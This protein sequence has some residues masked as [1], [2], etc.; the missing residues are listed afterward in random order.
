M[1]YYEAVSFLE[2]A[3]GFTGNLNFDE[4]LHLLRL[5]EKSRARCSLLFSEYPSR[6]DY[7][8]P[9]QGD[10][11]EK[12]IKDRMEYTKEALEAHKELTAVACEKA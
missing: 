10:T 11:L 12:K 4:V 7:Y 9:Y 6:G 1:N 8:A 2:K 3:K 5:Y